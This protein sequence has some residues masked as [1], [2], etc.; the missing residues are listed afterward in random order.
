MNVEL[1]S[2]HLTVVQKHEISMYAR[3]FGDLAAL[4]VWGTEAR[5]LIT[6]A[7]HSLG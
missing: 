6:A 1:V 7:I 2:A 3:A 5:A 4:A